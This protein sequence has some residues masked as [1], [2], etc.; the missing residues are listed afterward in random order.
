MSVADLARSLDGA[1]L[2]GRAWIA[3]CPLHAGPEG[4][5]TLRQPLGASKVRVRC[6]A[7]CSV[8]AIARA[9]GLPG[10]VVFADGVAENLPSEVFAHE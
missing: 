9:L 3:H 2:V 4:L 6:R 5:L 10:G 1:R 8:E 7:G